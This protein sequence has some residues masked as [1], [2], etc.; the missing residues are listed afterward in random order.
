MRRYNIA[1]IDS[2]LLHRSITHQLLEEYL[3]QSR[4]MA[5]LSEFGSGPELIQEITLSGQYDIYLMEVAMP[6]MNGITLA[7]QLRSNGDRG[8]IIY[9]T[10]DIGSAYLAFQVRAADYL[11]KPIQSERFKQAMDAAFIELNRENVSPVIELKTKAGLM[12]VPVD[13]ITY[14][15]VV[16]RALCFHLIN[17][18]QLQTTCLR[19]TFQRAVEDY[20]G[21][22][23]NMADF[24]Y[25]GKS[26]LLNLSY[27]AEL[28]KNEV[29]LIT[30][31]K[32][33]VPK[34]AIPS[35]RKAW[36][37]HKILF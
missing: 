17:G 4:F 29:T 3:K 21:Q 18:T 12:R 6:T 33:S 1:L 31:E 22:T 7:Q 28:S 34:S 2:N 24:I 8:I 36:L 20:I 19:N 32:L 13:N 9:L 11:L 10:Y 26:Q 14:V 30:G 25:A 5:S 16:G 23:T 27:I 37:S 15:N 35:I